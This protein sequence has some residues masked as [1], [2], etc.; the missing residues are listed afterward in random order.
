MQNDE[1]MSILKCYRERGRKDW[2]V[3]T[4]RRGLASLMRVSY[5]RPSPDCEC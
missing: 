5:F 4:L 3:E 2:P 1:R